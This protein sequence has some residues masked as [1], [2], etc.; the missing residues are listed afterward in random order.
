MSRSGLDMA[1]FRSLGSSLIWLFIT[2]SNSGRIP[3]VTDTLAISA[4]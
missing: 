1:F 3:D 2:C 4:Q